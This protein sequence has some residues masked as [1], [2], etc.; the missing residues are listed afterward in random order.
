MFDS[1]SGRRLAATFRV[2][3][4][5]LAAAMY[6]TSAWAVPDFSQSSIA[7]PAEPPVEGDLAA[8][9]VTLRN[10]GDQP[11]DP[12]QVTIEWPL[13]GHFVDLDG[14]DAAEIDPEARRI[15][16]S[17]ALPPG[18]SRVLTV[19][20]LAPRDSGGDALTLAVHVAH[21]FSGAEL[22]DRQ[23]ITVDTRVGA[24]GVSIGAYR[25]SPAGLAVVA[26]LILGSVVWLIVRLRMPGRPQ[27]PSSSSS[28]GSIRLGLGPTA[29]VA[30]LMIAV[31]FW[32][33]FAAMAW[34][35]HRALTAWTETTCTILGRRIVA[36]SSTSSPGTS[37]G[38]PRD[39]TVY[40]PELALRY[41]VDGRERYSTGFDTGSSLRVGGSA[42]RQGDVAAWQVGSTVPC[43]YD[44][45]DPAD[46]VVVRGFGG[47]YLFAL[48]PVPVFLLGLALLR[49]GGI[50]PNSL[51]S[52]ADGA[53]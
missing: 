50:R 45:A 47:A 6:F 2:V 53:R 26:W 44:P 30:A 15:R 27:A 41:T 43:W 42:G 1:W 23:T 21:Y 16:A 28:P 48:L 9:T 18:G 3:G 7:L 51:P 49:R 11:A 4:L 24:D 13:M 29:A 19:R 5:V 31:G 37:S 46:V 10:T 14:L 8:F 34:R 38:R 39:T 22:W 33:I 40:E 20:V 35:D 12:A 25:V 17:L 52:P 36:Q 32:M